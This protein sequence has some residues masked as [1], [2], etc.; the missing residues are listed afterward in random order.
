MSVAFSDRQLALAKIVRDILRAHCPPP[1]VRTGRDSRPAWAQLAEAGLFGLLVPEEYG[2]RGLGLA[3]AVLA[4]EET[5]RAA[6]PG[7]VAET[8]AA[9]PAL[10]T[11][12]ADL[13]TA[14]PTG[15]TCVSV[16]LGDQVYVPD[17]DLADLLILGDGGRAYAVPASDARLVLQ[18][19]VDPVRR[20]YAVAFEPGAGRPV[21]GDLTVALR[22][23]TVAVAAQLLGV[24]RNLLETSAG[25]AGTRRQPGVPSRAFQAVTRQLAGVAVAV[26]FAAPLVRRAALSVDAD[27][28][29]VARDVSAA[30]A[31]AG[32]AAE[33]AA[34]TALRVHGAI[35]YSAELDL[36][37]WLARVWSLSA[38]YGGTAVHRSSLRESLPAYP[39]PRP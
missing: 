7:P 2:G 9:A 33:R 15:R 13:L 20:L 30:K 11:G 12:E 35:G 6:L 17:A 10:L 19:G 25:Y 38:A 1:A 16:R 22:R 29:S 36:R 23:V 3:D 27:L 24:A 39:A 21:G 37:L 5:G 14:L 32:E 31:A 26:E 34:C 18:A 4:L 8:V 28:P